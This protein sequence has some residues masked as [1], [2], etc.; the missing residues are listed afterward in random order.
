MVT[1]RAW[2]NNGQMRA[3]A[4]RNDNAHRSSTDSIE[5]PDITST[6]QPA[7]PNQVNAENAI[8]MLV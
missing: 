3:L 5:A 4:S 2:V 7:K 1:T 6:P 8:V